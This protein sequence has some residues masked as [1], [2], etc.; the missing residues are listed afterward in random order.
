MNKKPEHRSLP[1]LQRRFLL[2]G[3]TSG[4]VERK[5]KRGRRLSQGEVSQITSSCAGFTL[6]EVLISMV[7]LSIS[8]LGLAALATTTIRSN[9]FSNDYTTAT[10]LAQDQLETLINTSFANLIPVGVTQNDPSNP[11][12]EQ[13]NGGGKYTRTWLMN[14]ITVGSTKSIAV[15]VTWTSAYG[16]AKNVAITS[17]RSNT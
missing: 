8:L 5:V 9:T 3:K 6:L 10:A 1:D 17:I 13:G 12:D 11:I 4:A 2:F 14:D 15:T 16:N 7:I